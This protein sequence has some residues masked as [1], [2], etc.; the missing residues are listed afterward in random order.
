MTMDLAAL[1]SAT[2]FLAEAEWRY[3][4]HHNKG[5]EMNCYAASIEAMCDQCHA[6]ADECDFW[7]GRCSGPFKKKASPWP[8][9]AAL[10][11]VVLVVFFVVLGAMFYWWMA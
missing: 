11:F 1:L 6:T 7:D 4:A 2:A 5:E 3:H 8:Y 9:F 10:V